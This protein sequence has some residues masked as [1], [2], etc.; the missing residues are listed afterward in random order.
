MCGHSELFCIVYSELLCSGIYSLISLQYN[1]WNEIQRK[2]FFDFILDQSSHPELKFILAWFKQPVRT[3]QDFTTILPRI[4]STHIFSYL[5]PRSLCR[6]ASV[7]WHWKWLVEQD[8]IWRRKCLK[9][10]WYLPYKPSELE[11]GAWK[12]HYMMCIRTLDIELPQKSVS[13]NN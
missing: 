7:S 4:V 9:F 2:R 6:A 11:N 3:Q 5:D 1:S 10:G 13:R 8:T 12:K